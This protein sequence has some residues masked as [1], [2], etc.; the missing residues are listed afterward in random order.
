MLYNLNSNSLL[1]SEIAEFLGKDLIGDDIV[2]Y[3]PGNDK[4]LNDNTII[5]M[6]KLTNEKMLEISKKNE[7]LTITKEI[8][9][10]NQNIEISY[11][12]SE[13][14]ELD[15]I[16]AIK[17]FFFNEINHFI[18][19]KAIIENGAIIGKNVTIHSG[20][21]I[22]SE[23]V[24]GEGSIIL[25]NVVITGKVDIGKNCVIKSNSVI[26]SEIFN[27]V[28]DGKHWEQFPQIGKIII[29]DN[30]WI[31]SSSTIEKGSLTDTIIQ[32][33]VRIDDLVQIGSGCR[34]GYKSIIAAGSVLCSNVIIENGCLIAPNVSILENLVIHS[35]SQ[36]GL[37]SVI[38]NN[39]PEN[40]LVVGNPA[41]ILKIKK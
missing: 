3:G 4:C 9:N 28:F 31:G 18:H 15:F 16:K 7:I 12:I 37:G 24:I 36:I 21:F 17:H 8:E 34:V 2:I 11:I 5:Y 26:G 40:V 10:K 33:D 19:E 25:N 35:N 32:S 14:P 30:V 29:E 41:K 13:N 20:S 1:A 27:F 23:V 38:I 6:N 39:I 22:G